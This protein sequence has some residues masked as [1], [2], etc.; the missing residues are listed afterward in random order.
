MDKKQPRLKYPTRKPKALPKD[1]SGN[2]YPYDMPDMAEGGVSEPEVADNIRPEP[3]YNP[4]PLANEGDSG[5][6]GHK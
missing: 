3:K 6:G 2:P 1:A 4:K 5:L